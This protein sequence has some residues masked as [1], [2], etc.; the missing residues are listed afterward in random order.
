[1]WPNKETGWQAT[2]PEEE[3]QGNLKAKE[4]RSG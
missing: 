4:K 2:S 1:M 3:R